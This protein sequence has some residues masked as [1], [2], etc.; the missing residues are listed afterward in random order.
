MFFSTL[1]KYP[2]YLVSVLLTSQSN[3]LQT[4]NPKF[5]DLKQQPCYYL[6]ILWID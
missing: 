5:N 3:D 4:P 6:M 1:G 2:G